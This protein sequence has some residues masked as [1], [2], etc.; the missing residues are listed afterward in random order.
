VLQTSATIPANAA[1]MFV[2]CVNF[3][4]TAYQTNFAPFIYADY[5]SVNNLQAISAAMGTLTSGTIIGSRVATSDTGARTELHY[6]NLFG[7][8]FGGIGGYDGS[9][10]QWYAKASDGKIY[11]GGGNTVVDSDGL[12][13][14]QGASSTNAVKWKSSSTVYGKIYNTVGAAAGLYLTNDAGNNAAEGQ[15][16]IESNTSGGSG[17][18]QMYINARTL[19]WYKNG[20][21]TGGLAMGLSGT[22]AAKSSTTTIQNTT[23][24]TSC[25]ITA[26]IPGN[27]AAVGD[28]IKITAAGFYSTTGTP[29]MRFRVFLG[30]TA[31]ANTTSFTPTGTSVSNR[32]WRME[33]YIPIRSVGASGT[34]FA[35]GFMTLGRSDIVDFVSTA[36]T[37]VNFTTNQAVDLRF[38]WGA[39][40]TSNSLTCTLLQ[41][42]YLTPD[43]TY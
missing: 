9:T 8:G 39:A 25:G 40:S 17:T 10:V 21:A 34:V 35:Q 4:G 19:K 22:M 6:N 41:I 32:G 18:G 36:P 27:K 42:E 7:M 15:I 24:E 13:F 11:A 37:T 31:V 16:G 14:V 43:S 38:T 12:S 20:T 30:S 28:C 26:T 29:T 5:I 23:T 2:V 1:D 33:V 3:S